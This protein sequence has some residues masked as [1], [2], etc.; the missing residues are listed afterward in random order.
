MLE[1]PELVDG[2]QVAEVAAG[3]VVPVVPAFVELAE[4][5]LHAAVSKATPAALTSKP[6][7]GERIR[8][9]PPVRRF[10]WCSLQSG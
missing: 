6:A 3:P 1:V 5:L 4:A 8:R 10:I 9:K 2:L 7:R